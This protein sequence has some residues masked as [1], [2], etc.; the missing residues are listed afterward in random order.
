MPSPA[1]H[2]LIGT[3]LGMAACLPRGPFHNLWNA[4]R[5]QKGLMLLLLL[6]ANAPDVDY[7]PG[8]IIG[9]INA[10]H[11]YYTH[12]LGWITLVALGAWLGLRIFR[13]T[14][15]W[16]SFVLIFL[17]LAS[18]LF[19]DW[20]TDDGRAPYGIM[21]L[22][23]FTDRFYISPV[24][25][26]WQLEKAEWRDVFQWHNL[27]AVGVEVAWCLPLVGVVLLGK[28]LLKPAP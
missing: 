15:G 28:R 8:V 14:A 13:P 24:N 21:A 26:F 4:A 1:G 2:T 20:I 16:R 25:I 5:Q 17:T 12:T 19:A 6:L 22:W 7:V 27:L 18:H 11:H 3:A 9:Q 23:P 10:Y